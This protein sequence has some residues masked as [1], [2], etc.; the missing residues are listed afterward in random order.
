MYHIYMKI[1]SKQTQQLISE[2][3]NAQFKS[4]H[5]LGWGSTVYNAPWNVLKVG[6]K[7]Y[8][9]TSVFCY[10][11][12]KYGEQ[13]AIIP[14]QQNFDI[15]IVMLLVLHNKG[16]IFFSFYAHINSVRGDN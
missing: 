8:C 11:V 3:Q 5:K 10:I 12:H 4:L 15:D 16:V 6:L 2:P 1:I 13:N 14:W 9:K 7:R